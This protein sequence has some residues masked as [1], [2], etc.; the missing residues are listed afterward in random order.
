MTAKSLQLI[1]TQNG[2]K[3]DKNPRS[4]DIMH[5]NNINQRT[6]NACIGNWNAWAATHAK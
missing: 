6:T 1:Q 3:R 4:K 2:S 5:P